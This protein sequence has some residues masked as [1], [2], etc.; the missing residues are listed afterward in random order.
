MAQIVPDG[1]LPENSV[2]TPQGNITQI[3]GGTRVGDNLF[4]S[5]EQ[6]SV[7]TGKTAFFNNALGIDNIFS[8]VTGGSISGIDGII[9][10][11]GSANLFLVNPNGIIFGKD[12]SLDIGGSFLAS[13]ASSILFADETQFSATHTQTEPL[14]KVSV[15]VGLQFGEMPGRIVN[16]SRATVDNDLVGRTVDP[17][18]AGLQVPSGKTLALVGGDVVLEGGNMRAEGGRIELGSVA[19]NSLVSLTPTSQGW[20]LSYEG[21]EKFQDISLFPRAIVDTSGERGGEIQLQGR[22]VTLTGDQIGSPVLVFSNTLETGAGGTL[23]VTASETVQLSGDFASILTQTEGAGSAGNVTIESRN[24]TVQDGA[25]IA[26]FAS[27]ADEGRGGDLTV[28]ASESVELIGTSTNGQFPSNLITQGNLGDAGNLTIKTGRLLIRDGAQVLASTF[29]AGQAGN[30]IVRASESVKL[31]GF[32]ETPNGE[33]SSGLFAQVELGATGDAGNLTIETG[34]LTVLNG[35][36][37]SSA[38]RNRGQGGNVNIT[39][40]DSILVSGTSP[41]ATFTRGSSGIFVSAEPAF[42]DDLGN[43]IITTADAGDLIIT[44]GQLT[45]ENGA[46]ISADNFGTGEGGSATLNVRQLLVQ[47]GGVVRAGSFGEGPGGI[48]TVNASESVEII[49]SGMIGA[50][51]VKSALFTQAEAAGDAGDL[52]ITTGSLIVRDGAEVTVSGKSSGDA[53]NLTVE[54]SS[55]RLDNQANISADTKAGQGNINLGSAALILR[56]SSRITTNAEGSDVTGGNININADVL[57][58]VE[59]SDISANSRDFRGGNVSVTTQG[60]F[61]TQFREQLTPESDITATGAN[62]SL[63]GTVEINTPDVDP[64]QGLTELPNEPVNVEVAQ[65]CQAAGTQASVAFFN[66]GR[67]GL[68]PNPYEP[69]SSSNIWEDIPLATQ[70]TEHSASTARAFVSPATPPNKIVEAQGWIVNGKGEVVLVAE[71][72]TTQ[73]RSRCSLR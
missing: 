48:L 54:A 69:I 53:G 50:E 2:V 8:R 37:I 40:S 61:G 5:F 20:A 9:K 42:E 14:L 18:V 64:S 66:T 24:L 17:L 32:V 51:P 1:T 65:G 57:A 39:A 58:A 7:L 33:F 63:N 30:L 6:F 67:G 71:M 55:I 62:S 26:S 36:Q 23:A 29:G 10:A 60:L 70:R 43:L 15:P 28:I 73:S 47:D 4:H 59:N 25:F 41:T 13:T 3:D 72:P 27:F 21:I 46:K 49:G 56:R 45:V 22:N 19:G 31:I 44:T 38:A 34:R 16:R 68:A 11:N 12:A 35:A 52:N